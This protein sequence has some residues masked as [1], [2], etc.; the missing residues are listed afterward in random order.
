M[1][2]YAFGIVIL[3]LVSTVSVEA[4]PKRTENVRVV[5]RHDSESSY[6]VSLPGRSVTNGGAEA[7]CNTFY[8]T[9]RCTAEG[10]STTTYIP[11]V[12]HGYNVTGATLTL[13]T[14]DGRVAIVNC[15][16]KYALRFDY[17]NRRSCRAPMT[18]VISVEFKG[19][20][21]R[22]FWPVSL[23]GRKL[24]SETYKIVAVR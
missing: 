18:D 19:D 23:D 9:T 22:L 10:G 7:T 4:G 13:Q 12:D 11:P 20:K 3:T 6:G 1:K 2:T 17:I 15:E 21:A 24:E 5:E 14:P 16:S 8:N